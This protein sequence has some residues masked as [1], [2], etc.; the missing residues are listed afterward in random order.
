[1]RHQCL[2]IVP[3]VVQDGLMLSKTASGSCT[4]LSNSQHAYA[5]RS[6]SDEVHAR[7]DRALVRANGCSSRSH[8]HVGTR[9]KLHG[10][11]LDALLQC[12]CGLPIGQGLLQG[13]SRP[14]SEGGCACTI[15][16]LRLSDSSARRVG[17]GCRMV[18]V[19]P[20]V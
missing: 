10:S 4:T 1:M 2:T 9:W 17:G 13:W 11:R 3:G 15:G 8:A 12:P 7:N 5:T 14:F 18:S 16:D 20:R 19:L 6:D